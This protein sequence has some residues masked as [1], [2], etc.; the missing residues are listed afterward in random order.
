MLVKHVAK[1]HFAAFVAV[2]CV[3]GISGCGTGGSSSTTPPPSVGTPGIT[4]SSSA[5]DFGTVLT[6]SL[7]ATQVVTVTSSGTAPLVVSALSATG[8]YQFT[9][10][11]CPNSSTTPASLAVGSTCKLTLQFSPF[12]P[13]T[14]AGV[15]TV[16]TNVTAA[17]VPTLSLTGVGGLTTDGISTGALSFGT[18]PLGS[19]SAAQN[20]TITASATAP[21]ELSAL[22]TAGDFTRSATN[23][24][25]SLPAG[26]SCTVSLT[27][28]PTALAARTGTLSIGSDVAA[29]PQVVSLT[30]IGSQ[31]PSVAGMPITVRAL[32]GTTPIA[33]ASLQ[34]YAAGATGPRAGATALLA[35]GLVTD[36]TGTASLTGYTCPTAATPVY[37]LAKSGKVGT[38]LVPNTN[39]LLMTAIGPC[40]AIAAGS[41]YVVSESTSVA[42]GYALQQFY[43]AGGVIGASSTNLTGL[44]NAFGTA[45]QLIDPT[46]GATPANLPST[47]GP[48]TARVNT[49]ANL[50]NSCVANATQCAGLYAAA[51]RNGVTPVN[52]LDALYNL[53]QAPSA[54]T[55]AVYSQ[56][57]LSTAYSPA[58]TATPS[59]FTLFFKYTGGGLNSPSTIGVDSTGSVWVANYFYVASKFTPQGVPVFQNGVG[60]LG[61]N[62][63]YGLAVD[64]YDQAW[65]PDEQPFTP[66]GIGDVTILNPQGSSNFPGG[67]IQLGGFNY[68]LAVAI[69]PNGTTWVVDYGNSHLT[70]VNSLGTPTSGVSG[71]TTSLF[72]F[73]VAVAIDANHFGWIANQSNNTVTKV[74]PDGSSFVNYN[75]CMGASGIAIDQGNNVWV[76][77]FYGDS[78]SLISNAGVVIGNASYTGNGGL[79]RPQGIALD[80]NGNVWVA[81]Y[82]QTY[83][84]ELSGSGSTTPGT[85]LTPATGYGADA[86]LLEAY[87]LAI[88][89][90]GN[91]WV[92]N[93]GSNTVTKYIGLA[94]P[95]KTPLSALPKAP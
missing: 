78:V 87:A 76:A 12:A 49:L 18:V 74:A 47:T 77:N 79:S 82:R 25:A 16:G 35:A 42:A 86:G 65:I 72:A 38:A 48:P 13:G 24:S 22:T 95:V 84:T 27:F 30:G 29:S 62:N 54:N 73:P 52:T 92:S 43:A 26:S 68:P 93:Q 5:L 61:L 66:Y 34:L 37:L 88:D 10:N 69:D 9:A 40:G 63:S 90:S 14:R 33:G 11:D 41:T 28:T 23:C 45:T 71:Y 4:F 57:Q 39:T 59:D 6:S 36:A 51:Q 44:T 58:L 80:G 75:C 94:A 46:T 53:A 15:A 91:I 21:L 17:T 7:S 81:N 85:S 67:G 55:A 70:L 2:C 50:L 83:L 20:V 8:D 31:P 32:A 1:G 56:A 60:G 19:T 3:L 89:A 64:L